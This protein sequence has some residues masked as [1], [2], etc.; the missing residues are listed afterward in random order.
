MLA[1]SR[2]SCPGAQVNQQYWPSKLWGAHDHN[3]IQHQRVTL[4]SIFDWHWPSLMSSSSSFLIYYHDK[5]SASAVKSAVSL[6]KEQKKK[7]RESWNRDCARRH[8]RTIAMMEKVFMFFPS[9]NI[10]IIG[11]NL[12]FHFFWNCFFPLPSR[13][14]SLLSRVNVITFHHFS[15]LVPLNWI[16][17]SRFSL[18]LLLLFTWSN[19]SILCILESSLGL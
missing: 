13:S 7:G 14:K 15:S 12:A 5:S 8:F 3:K 4:N 18:L 1:L 11:W 9:Q 17:F 10:S 6:A 2:L 19:F 16:K